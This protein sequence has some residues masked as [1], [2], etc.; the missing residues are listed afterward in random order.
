[1]V[2]NYN[3]DAHCLCLDMKTEGSEIK[4]GDSPFEECHGHW[5]KPGLIPSG[6][7]LWD[8]HC[9]RYLGFLN[10]PTPTQQEKWCFII[11]K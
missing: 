11:P 9:A 4:K 8:L 7:W 1:M 5:V 3:H 6:F 2:S 10:Q